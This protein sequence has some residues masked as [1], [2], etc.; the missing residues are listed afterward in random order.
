LK[1]KRVAYVLHGNYQYIS[2]AKRQI[3]VLRDE[4][5]EVV[6][7]NG[8]FSKKKIKD[9][10]SDKFNKFYIVE[11]RNKLYNFYQIIKFNIKISK[12]L[13]NFDFIICRELSVLPA[14]VFAKKK[15]PEIK[16]IFDSNELSVETFSGA[17]KKIWSFIQKRSLKY[18]DKVIHAEKNR[19][20]YFIKNYDK[21]NAKRHITIENYPEK[22][23]NFVYTKRDQIK[24]LYFGG[25]SEGRKLEEIINAFGKLKNVFLDIVGYGSDEYLKKLNNIIDKNG[26]IN[27]KILPPISD[28]VIYKIFPDYSIGLAFYSNTNLNN[29]YC[30]PNKIFQYIQSGLAVITNNYP[31]L[32]EVIEKNKIGVC[33]EEISA[34]KIGIAVKCIIENGY[35]YNITETVRNEYAWESIFPKFLTIFNN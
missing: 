13:N 18:V 15:S 2:R 8:L 5:I 35:I 31:G 28:S 11:N 23:K 19:M 12:L 21:T 10:L 14:G 26:Y 1:N 25:I 27:I 33:I 32:K 16:L 34:E 30:A 20:N 4:G 6:I 3:S 7:F 22:N 29:Y 24:A 17:K 9:E